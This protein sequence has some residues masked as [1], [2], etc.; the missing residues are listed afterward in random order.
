MPYQFEFSLFYF[1]L[2]SYTSKLITLYYVTF[3]GKPL[4]QT[5]ITYFFLHKAN[6]TSY[7]FFSLFRDLSIGCNHFW[8]KSKFGLHFR[9]SKVNLTFS[10]L[11]PFYVFLNHLVKKL[12]FFPIKLTKFQDNVFFCFRAIMWWITGCSAGAEAVW[13]FIT[14]FTPW[15]PYNTLKLIFYIT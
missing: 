4:L 7:V 15:N 11:D 12:R 9:K 10:N 13:P 3:D 1:N 6:F 14:V 2:K 8:K 5:N